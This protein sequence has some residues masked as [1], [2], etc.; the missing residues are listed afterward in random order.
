M[1][2]RRYCAV[3]VSTSWTAS[4]PWMA[5]PW[6][7]K[8]HSGSS[9]AICSSA[10]T[11]STR[12]ALHFLRIAAVGRPPDDE[13]ARKQAALLGQ[14]DEAVVI[15]L[16]F[17]GGDGHVRCAEAELQTVAERDRRPGE[18]DGED[19]RLVAEL[20]AVDR[21]IEALRQ[22]IA[23]EAVDAVFLGDDLGPIAG[24]EEGPHAEDVIDMAVRVDRP[25]ARAHRSRSARR[26]A[27]PPRRASC[28]CRSS[29]DRPRS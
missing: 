20:A 12:V 5:R 14:P 15:R 26:H 3:S 10:F 2:W 8:S 28:R 1:I 17:A 4:R 11:Q 16:A 18:V 25:N 27:G 29:A 24:I 21:L 6:P 13:I 7:G 9:A 22:L 23:L 19:G